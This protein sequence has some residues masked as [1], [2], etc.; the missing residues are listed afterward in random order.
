MAGE[1]NVSAIVKKKSIV[2]GEFKEET[3]LIAGAD[4]INIEDEIEE[5]NEKGEDIGFPEYKV[6]L[7]LT[8]DERWKARQVEVD[9]LSSFPAYE[10]VPKETML[11]D[12]TAIYISSRWEENRKDDGT[13]RSRWVLREFN[14][15]PTRGDNFAPTPNEA[16]V[17]A[18]HMRALLQGHSIRYFD[19]SRAFP[20]APE[21]RNIWTEPPEGY[22]KPG[23]VWR[24]LR[25]INGSQD[26]SKGFSDWFR[27]QMIDLGFESNTI[28][29]TYYTKSDGS[30]S[31]S[32]HVDDGCCEGSDDDLDW[33]FEELGQRM[34]LK[35]TGRLEPGDG[36]SR[37]VTFLSRERSRDGDTI[38][39]KVNPKFVTDSMKLLGITSGDPAPTPMSKTVFAKSDGTLLDA[40]NH[41]LFRTI[42]GKLIHIQ[43][44]Y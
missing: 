41:S 12:P 22:E 37:W 1:T 4:L 28:T 39:K 14:K 9:F 38:R 15:G 31:V 16:E 34:I 18:L 7:P 11:A 30:M 2:D 25:K 19:V 42:V 29:A 27:V 24:A 26:G 23:M 8:D 17:D 43:P 10:Y 33:L 40:T 35:E 36:H 3:F 5:L 13:P 21:E 32:A 44:D 6:D 20:H